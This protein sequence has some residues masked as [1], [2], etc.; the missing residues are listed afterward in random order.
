MLDSEI[1]DEMSY[2]VGEDELGRLEAGGGMGN[3][4][5]GRITVDHSGS[6]WIK[7]KERHRTDHRSQIS[8]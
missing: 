2:M 8:G 7:V 3:S 4:L 1:L 6:Q 5:V